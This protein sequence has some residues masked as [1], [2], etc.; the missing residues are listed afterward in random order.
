MTSALTTWVIE[1]GGVVI[2][3]QDGGGYQNTLMTNILG[4]G[5]TR[6]ID[7][8]DSNVRLTGVF[9]DSI[10]NQ[11][12][13]FDIAGRNLGWDG[14]GNSNYTFTPALA[15]EV[16]VLA[17]SAGLSN[18]GGNPSPSG[19][20]VALKSKKYGYLLLG[21]G[22]PFCG[23]IPG[24][25]NGS[26]GYRPLTVSEANLPVPRNTGNYTNTHNSHFFVNAMIWA[27]QRRLA[28]AP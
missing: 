20:A 15:A 12:G 2:H 19:R 18:G 21:D 7:R 10:V 28:V 25:S 13:Y 9:G 5:I 6:Q 27:I 1:H 24:Y 22:G 14:D 4:P 8:T 16:D 11:T 26:G 17:V 23:G 3:C